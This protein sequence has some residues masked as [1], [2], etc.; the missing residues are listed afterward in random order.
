MKALLERVSRYMK[1]RTLIEHLNHSDVDQDMDVYVYLLQD[2]SS[3]EAAN[4]QYVEVCD[5][6]RE[7]KDPCIYLWC[8]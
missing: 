3:A 7:R 4:I 8:R 1:V 2:K 5:D 6:V